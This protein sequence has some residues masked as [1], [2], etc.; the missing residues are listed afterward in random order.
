MRGVCGKI[1]AEK[2]QNA[3]P[4]FESNRKAGFRTVQTSH[5]CL[6]PAHILIIKHLEQESSEVTAEFMQDC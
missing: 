1:K 2:F 4:R 6:S 5:S 3:D